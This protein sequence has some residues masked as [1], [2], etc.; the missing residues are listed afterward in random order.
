MARNRNILFVE[1][2]DDL[3]VISHICRIFDIPETFRIT[4]P[5]NKDI[6]QFDV[7]DEDTA[8][9]ERG[10]INNVLKAAESALI[11]SLDFIQKVGIVIDADLNLNARWQSVSDILKRAGYENLPKLPDPDGTIIEQEFKPIFGVWIM[12]DNTIERG[13]LETFLRFLVP[14]PE[15]NKNWKHAQKSVAELEDKPFIKQ[16]ADHTEKA[17]IYTYL[18]WQKEPGKP[19][20]QAI[21][22]K[23]LQADNP[24]CEVFVEWLNRLFVQ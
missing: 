17:E 18:A 1:G 21:T 24:K 6:I 9:E 2:D 16:K 23:Y 8:F 12:P 14:D 7:A 13:F 3:H 4:I 15:N 19:F 10:G 22:A 5:K 20:G 11:E